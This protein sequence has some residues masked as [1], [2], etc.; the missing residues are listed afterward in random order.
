[1]QGP[2]E[3]LKE[4]YKWPRENAVMP[5]ASCL[6]MCHCMSSVDVWS[7]TEPEGCEGVSNGESVSN[8]ETSPSV[9]GRT[10]LAVYR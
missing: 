7:E 5:W 1:M 3:I 8:G 6:W 2:I 9:S 4:K 10:E